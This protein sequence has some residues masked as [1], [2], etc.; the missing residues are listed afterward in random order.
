[1]TTQK[2]L[3]FVRVIAAVLKSGLVAD[4]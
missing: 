4:D 2:D 3:G 1:V